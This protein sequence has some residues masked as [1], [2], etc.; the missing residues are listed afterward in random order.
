MPISLTNKHYP[1]M[2]CQEVNSEKAPGHWLLARL[3]K[4]ILRPGGIGMTRYMLM[5]LN[6]KNSDQVVEFAPGLGITAKM[7]LLKN[8][9]SYT[10]IEQDITATEQVNQYLN[11]VTQRCLTAGAHQTGLPSQC[12]TVVYG[13]AMLSMQSNSRKLEIMKEAFRILK[14]GGR[15][16]IHELCLTPTHISPELQKTIQRELAS[17]LKVGAS[18][19]IKEQWVML[20]QSAGFKVIEISTAPMALLEPGR[21]LSDEGLFRFVKIILRV[22]K[23]PS[24]WKRI[25]HMHSIFRKYQDNLAAVVIIAE[26]Q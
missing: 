6:I 24:A 3:G 18:P 7:A 19:L 21:I 1:P 13:E 20:L 14:P 26:K 9:M 5:R 10:A 2:P 12:A 22:L 16:A 4:R 11:G 25:S 23:E 17:A 15:Y 8:P